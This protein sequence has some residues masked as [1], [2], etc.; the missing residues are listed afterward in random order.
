MVKLQ[1]HKRRLEF[2]QMKGKKTINNYVRWITWLVN[3]IKSCGETISEQNDVTKILCFLTET[4][5]NIVVVIEDQRI[6]RRWVKT[7]FKAL[8]RL[9]SKR[10]MREMLIRQTRRLLC[11]LVSIRRRRSRKKNGPWRVNGIIRILEEKSIKI[12]RIWLIKGVRVVV[13]KLVVKTTLK[14]KKESMTKIVSDLIKIK[15]L[16]LF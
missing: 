1:T 4:L 16:G 2:I 10:W 11:G 7:S 14:A 15:K 5:D 12:Q 6:L 8:L 3:Q 9:M 13:A